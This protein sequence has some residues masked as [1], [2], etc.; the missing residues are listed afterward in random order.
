MI[1]ALVISLILLAGAGV[2]AAVMYTRWRVAETARADAER[3]FTEASVSRDQAMA[4]LDD[5]KKRSL[6]L[7]DAR[8][9]AEREL[10][11]AKERL[12]GAEKRFTEMRQA[13]DEASSAAEKRLREAFQ[14]LAGDALK[15]S[16]EQFLNLA[17]EKLKQERTE[18]DKQL[19]LRKKEVEALV[20]PIS[21]TLKSYGESLKAIET[22]RGEAYGS[23]R[24]QLTQMVSDQQMLRRETGNLVKALRR[25]DVRGR[26]GE[27]QLRR[28]AEL[29]GMIE[30]CDFTEQETT[31]G[32]AAL[33]PD[34]IVKLPNDR[35]IVVDA[36]TPID[37]Y[38]SALEAV[39]DAQ[40][41]Q[42]MTR[43]ASQVQQKVDALSAKQYWSQFAR[44]PDFVVLFI[45]GESFL[46]AAVQVRPDL[47]ERAME[48]NVV[49]ATPSTLIALLKAVAQ[50][51]REEKVAEHAEQVA[52][53][54]RE[55]HERLCVAMDNVQKLGNALE[56]S[57][58]NYN[59]LVGSIEL[60]VLP[61]ARK[62]EEL[63]VESA[64]EL[65]SPAGVEGA[66]REVKALR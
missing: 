21:D 48:R 32:D 11:V 50:G 2:L 39:D 4:Q 59:A 38:L 61:S 65:T 43:H 62:F 34:M 26:W 16:S 28:V 8:T 44:S 17:S 56:S 57:V 5:E 42:Q 63:G 36:K 18:A 1:P 47:M 45:P 49:I 7:T 29:A 6:S 30:N 3:R 27:V 31:A 51:W 10:A 9:H 12:D 14:S 13:L 46:Y 15:S 52:R 41:E 66:P 60:R 37:A 53:L 23:L 54:G 58:K 20:K 55:L 35:S 19:E 24:Q 33:R 64:K 25:P 40:R 22:A